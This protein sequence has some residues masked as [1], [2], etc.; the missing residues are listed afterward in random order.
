MASLDLSFGNET[1]RLTAYADNVIRVRIS[2]VFAFPV[3]SIQYLPS[4]RCKLGR[5]IILR[6]SGR[7]SVR[8]P[9]RWYASTEHT[10][11][12]PQLSSFRSW[13]MQNTELLSW[14]IESF[15]S[16]KLSYY[17]WSRGTH[18]RTCGFWKITESG[19]SSDAGWI[20]LWSRRKQWGQTDR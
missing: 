1:L 3:W 5:N 2:R 7:F 6:D 14:Q 4:G 8:L 16:G 12:E 20:F 19:V 9:V 18:C 17:R 11:M 15:P 10:K 13:Y